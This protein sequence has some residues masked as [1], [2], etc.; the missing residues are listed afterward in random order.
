MQCGRR[1]QRSGDDHGDAKD[2]NDARDHPDALSMLREGGRMRSDSPHKVEAVWPRYD[3][4]V[5]ELGLDHHP[6]VDL[7][8]GVN[9]NPLL[10]PVCQPDD[11][12]PSH[13]CHRSS[14]ESCTIVTS[15]R[16]ESL[17]C[18]PNL[19]WINYIIPVQTRQSESANLTIYS[20]EMC[21][22]FTDAIEQKQL[23]R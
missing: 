8:I 15:N 5:S 14:V 4:S 17:R 2:Q 23:A 6:G 18:P 1:D 3:A 21:Q 19:D 12:I 10:V 20:S 9:R 13:C 22:P 7:V 16:Q 11:R